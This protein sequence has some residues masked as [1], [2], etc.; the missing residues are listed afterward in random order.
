MAIVPGAAPNVGD[1]AVTGS[2]SPGSVAPPGPANPVSAT[3]AVAGAG[4]GTGGAQSVPPAETRPGLLRRHG[5]FGVLLVLA[6]AAR[7]VVVIAYPGG[8]LYHG[9]SPAYLDQAANRLWPGDWRPSGY[10]I[11][12]RLVGGHDHL[13]WLVVIQQLLTLAAGVGLYAVARRWFTRAWPAALSAAPA[14]LAPW[15]LDLGQ[16][17]L[18]EGL[19]GV[20]TIAGIA[21]LARPGR[22]RLASAAL[23]GL[24]LG[25]SL[26]VRTVGYGPL[27]VGVVGLVVILLGDRRRRR[28]RATMADPGGP[29]EPGEPAESA[30]NRIPRQ[31][32]IRP[33][34]GGGWRAHS[35]LIML[36]FLV[37]AAGPIVAYSTWSA[38]ET[39]RFSVSAHSGFFLYG[40]VAPFADCSR[41]STDE[42]RSLCDPRPID[43]RGSPVT[44]LWPD[45]SPLRQGNDDVPPGREELAGRFAQE[46]IRAQPGMMIETSVRYLAGY[47]LP[48]RYETVLTSRADTWELPDTSGNR[49]PPDDPHADDGYFTANRL[50]DPPAGALAAYTQVA[51]APMPFVGLGLIA[52]VMA[53]VADRVRRAQSAGSA[54]AT[55]PV[56]SAGSPSRTGPRSSA[57]SLSSSVFLS[58]AGAERPAGPGRLFWLAGGAGMSTLVLSSLTSGF[59]YR[60]LAPVIGLLGV[61]A[62]I[63]L[64]SFA[65]VWRSPAA[66][67]PGWM[68]WSPPR[69][70]RGGCARRDR[71]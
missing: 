51:Y 53:G 22:P 58:S 61:A 41:L 62:A 50:R 40:R 57:G 28:D 46:I 31:R 34:T 19:F 25:A 64:A 4:R 11:F 5:A 27:A 20:L 48:V 13:T 29:A 33:P 42:L 9:D 67:P 38:R 55:G 37:G 30:G 6:V 17:V 56:S 7:V 16:F 8:I 39:G 44:Y 49:L 23:A 69:R 63:G 45:D 15:V 54:V 65:Q 21:L 36:A 24:L 12:L 71:T 2:S 3:A 68:R 47:F 10:P 32:A 26:T 66:R 70:W 35:V 52:G 60:Y 18:A 43:Q 1:S 59:D 14:L